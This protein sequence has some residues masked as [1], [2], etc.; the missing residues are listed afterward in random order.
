MW[1]R[2]FLVGLLIGLIFVAFSINAQPE[3][4]EI[5]QKLDKVLENQEVMFKYLKFIKNK[6]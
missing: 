2:G 3:Q 4:Q 1:F 6:V 5:V